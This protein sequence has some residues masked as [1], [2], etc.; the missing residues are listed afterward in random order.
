MCGQYLWNVYLLIREIPIHRLPW[1]FLWWMF[2]SYCFSFNINGVHCSHSCS[3]FR[4]WNWQELLPVVRLAVGPP[5]SLTFWRLWV[6]VHVAYMQHSAAIYQLSGLSLDA[7][8]YIYSCWESRRPHRVEPRKSVVLWLTCGADC[9]STAP[10]R[11][12]GGSARACGPLPS[13]W[14]NGCRPRDMFVYT[15][16]PLRCPGRG[17]A[18]QVRTNYFYN[19]LLLFLSSSTSNG[20]LLNMIMHD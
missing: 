3:W 16:A 9:A 5:V 2:L 6:R 1:V 20:D 10:A 13:D 8:R 19:S 17:S 18:R 11:L 12:P 7:T 4:I 14:A 15:S